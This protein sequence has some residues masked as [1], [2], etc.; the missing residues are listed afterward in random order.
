MS[1]TARGALDEALPP[2]LRVVVRVVLVLVLV[3]V[4]VPEPSDS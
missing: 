1:S 4:R 2:P 3:L